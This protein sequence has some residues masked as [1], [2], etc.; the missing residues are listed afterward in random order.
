MG[1]ELSPGHPL[2][3]QAGDA[4][5]LVFNPLESSAESGGTPSQDPSDAT[6]VQKP[7]SRL[8]FPG[9]QPLSPAVEE[10]TDVTQTL[11]REQAKSTLS[12]SGQPAAQAPEPEDATLLTGPQPLRFTQD[13]DELP[14]LDESSKSTS[15]QPASQDDFE[16]YFTSELPSASNV[17]DERPSPSKE[18][19]DFPELTLD[20]LPGSDADFD[21]DQQEAIEIKLDLAQA[22]LDMDDQSGARAL[23]DEVLREGNAVEQERAQDIL[24][25][26][27]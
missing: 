15:D 23:L 2:F 25:R 3:N 6:Q 12:S 14:S 20:D 1:N 4:D 21:P 16:A 10:R 27:S 9:E 18:T 26:L 13:A 24:R 17:Y 22:Y 5:T 7:A 11:P 8:A 19:E